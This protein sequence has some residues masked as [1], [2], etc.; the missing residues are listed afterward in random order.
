MANNNDHDDDSL[1]QKVAATIRPLKHKLQHLSHPKKDV[2][3]VKIK[4]EK[5]FYDAAKTAVPIKKQ[6]LSEAPDSHWQRRL[7][8]GDINI[9]MILD[10]HGC[11]QREAY[12]QLEK[13]IGHARRQKMR[14]LLVITGKGKFSKGDGVLKQ[15]LPHWLDALHAV[16]MTYHPAHQKHGG[17]GAMYVVLKKHA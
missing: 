13:F 11:T 17:S 7:K 4:H 3:K 1:W 2:P 8:A 6:K 12:H 9:E 10:L 16:I 15:Q 14:Q 5:I